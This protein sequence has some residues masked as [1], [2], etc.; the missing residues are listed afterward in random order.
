MA[1][2]EEAIRVAQ[3]AVHATLEDH[4]DRVAFLSNLG[5]RL[6]DRYSRT[7]ATADLEEAF[8]VAQEAV[9]TTPKAIRTGLAIRVAQEA[10]DATPKRPS[11]PGWS[12]EQ[13][14]TS[15]WR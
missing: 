10:V 4:P 8:R 3:E 12:A 14:R 6:S 11:S 2:L 15:S 9:D 1:G 13:P 5:S 7:G